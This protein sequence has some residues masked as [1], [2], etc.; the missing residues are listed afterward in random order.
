MNVDIAAL[1]ADPDTGVV[2]TTP[3]KLVAGLLARRA[4]GAGPIAVVP[5]D[6]VPDN[7]AMAARVVEQLAAAVDSTLPGW[8]A[9]SV[10]WVSTMVDRI[11]PRTTDDDASER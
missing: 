11:T 3:G 4:A 6:N 7:G 10:S 2:V 1:R 5:N 9:T 8:I